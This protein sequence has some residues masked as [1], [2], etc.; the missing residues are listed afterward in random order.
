[1]M[2]EKGERKATQENKGRGTQREE[3]ERQ[4]RERPEEKEGLYEMKVVQERA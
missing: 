4:G 2:Q 1:M 3:R